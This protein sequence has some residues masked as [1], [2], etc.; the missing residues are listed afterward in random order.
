ML[1]SISVSNKKYIYI[2]IYFKTFLA[3]VDCSLDLVNFGWKKCWN[4]KSLTKLPVCDVSCFVV[5]DELPDT[6]KIPPVQRARYT[7]DIEGRWT[8]P[9]PHCVVGSG[10]GSK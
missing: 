6:T 4:L 5:P 1:I 8:P 3:Y 2:I 10:D 7:C 9:L